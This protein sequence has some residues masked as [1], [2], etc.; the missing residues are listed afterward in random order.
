MN[1]AFTA[2]PFFNDCA[3]HDEMECIKPLSNGNKR[4]G[5]KSALLGSGRLRISLRCSGLA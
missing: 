5:C 3:V 1:N 2:K 4:K